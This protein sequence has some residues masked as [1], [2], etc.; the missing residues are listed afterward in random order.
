MKRFKNILVLSRQGAGDKTT[1]ERAME[2]AAKNQAS[3]TVVDVIEALPKDTR[4][5]ATVMSPQDLQ[6]LAIENRREELRRFVVPVQREGVRV[7]IDVLVGPPFVQIIRE[8]LRNGHDLLMMTANGT[9]GVK[10]RLLGSTSLHLLRK[11][12][13]PVWVVKPGRT[14][15]Y[16]RIMAAVDPDTSDEERNQVN[17]EIMDLATSLARSEES[18]LHVVHAWSVWGAKYVRKQETVEEMAREVRAAHKKQVDELLESYSLE[19]LRCRLYLLKG[20]PGRVIP[21]VASQQRIELIVMGTVSRTG[22]AGLFIGN[23]AETVL[24]EVDCSVLAVKPKR[25]VSPVEREDA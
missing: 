13:C 6:D 25:F 5:L 19:A 15:R 2:L 1:L 11:C 21:Q 8:V 23:T 4:K 22:L 20:D 17:T 7:N 3:L 9:T 16:S 14:M 24:Q 12:P 18:E 10:A